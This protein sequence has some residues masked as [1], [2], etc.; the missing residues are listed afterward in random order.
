ML[1]RV[2]ITGIGL[3]SS[4]GLTRESSWNAM[5][6][7]RCGIDDLAMFPGAG[8]RSRKV[9]QVPI[10]EPDGRF[11]PYEQRRYSRCDQMA[12]MAATE[13]LADAGLIES[14]AD[15]STI[16]VVF[17]AG[18]G[19]LLRVE[20]YYAD[21]LDVGFH[22]ARPSNIFNYFADTPADTVAR[23]F[24]L[25]GA[26]A[27]PM[28]ACSSSAMAIGYAGDLVASGQLEAALAGGSDV[29]CQLT[30]AGFNAL[31]LVDAE[32]CRPFDKS[33]NGMNIGEGGA[34][35][36]LESLDAARARGAHV[37]AELAGYAACCEAHHA[38]APEPD[39][40]VVSRLLRAALESSGVETGQVDHI[41][42]HG[43]AT[44]QNDRA[45]AKGIRRVFEDRTAS[46]PVTSI[47]SMVG[48]CLGAAGAI[49]AAA[50]ALTI[51]RKIIPPTIHHSETDPEC[52]VAIVAN[53]AREADVRCGVSISLALGGNDAPLVIRH[54]EESRR[55]NGAW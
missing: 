23:R 15:R 50:L 16:G 4:L 48:H 37:Y 17:G 20:R 22:G 28:S 11:T 12:V 14:G 52:P 49:E 40:L 18:T 38:T 55:M 36:V 9:A 53:V 46:I 47:K 2:A 26:R 31:R 39:G 3:I 42:A 24:Q 35:L 7:G 54:A 27:C 33:R 25:T 43:T 51:D 1:R 19:D 5:V 8:Y 44:P 32:P 10:W 13:A 29:L 45:E 30:L 41:N 6:E 34:V 21:V